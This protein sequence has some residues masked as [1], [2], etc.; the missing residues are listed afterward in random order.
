MVDAQQASEYLAN[1]VLEEHNEESRESTLV[2][3]NL[4]NDFANDKLPP[5]LHV[6]AK[7]QGGSQLK[8]SSVSRSNLPVVLSSYNSL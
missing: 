3:A 4:V 8:A 5:N 7:T 2:S 6:N 1:T